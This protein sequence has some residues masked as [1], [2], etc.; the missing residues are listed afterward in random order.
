MEDIFKIKVKTIKVVKSNIN[1]ASK[2]VSSIDSLFKDD[3]LTFYFSKKEKD[4][5]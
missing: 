3:F 5:K 1:T 4:V 2:Q